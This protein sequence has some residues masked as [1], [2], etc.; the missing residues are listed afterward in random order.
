M[1]SVFLSSIVIFLSAVSAIE[2]AAAD[3][4]PNGE[5][6]PVHFYPL[7]VP[8]PPKLSYVLP[9][10]EP[11]P[12]HAIPERTAPPSTNQA[13]PTTNHVIPTGEPVPVH[14]GPES[15]VPPSTGQAF[16]SSRKIKY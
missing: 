5:P 7:S 2:S 3:V 14:A 1:A 9:T 13:F 16:P 10:G 15:T 6:V 12:V 4:F 8:L 11:V